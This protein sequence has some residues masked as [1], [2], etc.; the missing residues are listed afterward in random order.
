MDGKPH[1]GMQCIEFEALLADALDGALEA[2]RM[3]RFEAHAAGCPD[4]GPLLAQSRAGLQWMKSL[5]EVE[6]PRHLVHNILAATTG[7]ERKEESAARA[8]WLQRFRDWIRPVLVPT[9]T[10]V[11]QPRFAMSFGM[12]FFSLSLVMNLAGVKLRDLGRLDLRPGAIRASYYETEAKVV[13][14]YE[15]MRL[16]YELQS[17]MRDLRNATRPEDQPPPPPAPQPKGKTRDDNTS[18]QPEKRNQY[19]S[20]DQSGMLL[21]A[22][23]DQVSHRFFPALEARDSRPGDP[24]AGAGEHRRGA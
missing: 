3:S 9:W 13:R 19:Y 22:L 14:Y 8:G 2:Q 17:R 24:Q 7:V 11:R 12:A 23:E 15:N 20:S 18:G 16:V 10:T 1:N 21:A 6:P 5:Q 4:C